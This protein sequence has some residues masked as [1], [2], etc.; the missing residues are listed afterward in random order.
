MIQFLK[1]S[2]FAI[3]EVIMQAWR[4]LCKHYFSILGLFFSMFVVFNA[5]GLLSAYFSEY[6]FGISRILALSIALLF[7]ILYCGIQLTLFKYLIH[8]IDHELDR[9]N[10]F[11]TLPTIKE[12]LYFFTAFFFILIICIFTCALTIVVI[13]PLVFLLI[14][15]LGI[16]KDIGFNIGYGAGAL[17]TLALLIR[18]S[19]YP[20][21]ILDRHEKPFNAIRLSLAITKGNFSKLLLF[22]AFYAIL[23]LLS[24]YFTY[25]GLTGLVTGLSFVNSF[26]VVPFSSI[27]I[28]V[29][30]RR[31]TANYKGDSNPEFMKNII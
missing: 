10:V 5:S 6:L 4:I 19:F 7:F 3:H 27:L 30:Y 8:V 24:I 14:R 15:T 20:F 11:K 28:A 2:T 29:A 26:F 18:I 13:F 31:M 1:E 22:L 9:E 23:Q 21:F 12:M 25:E 16:G 17:V